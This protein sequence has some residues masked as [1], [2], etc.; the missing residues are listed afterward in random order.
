MVQLGYMVQL[1]PN[2][3]VIK[4]H[5]SQETTHGNL[6]SCV[7]LYLKVSKGNKTPAVSLLT[8]PAIHRRSAIICILVA[9]IGTLYP[10]TSSMVVICYIRYTL[11]K[12]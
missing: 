2:R 8:I 10:N 3:V 12:H 11:S 9:V 1:V 7:C 6:L 4:S 5:R